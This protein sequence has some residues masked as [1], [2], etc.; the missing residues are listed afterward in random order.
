MPDFYLEDRV[1]ARADHP[2]IYVAGID[3]VGIGALAGPVVAA[4]VVLPQNHS[5][6]FSE[7]NDSKKLPP[8]TRERLYELIVS[9]AYAVGIGRA[10]NDKIDSDGIKRAHWGAL[11]DAFQEVDRT[12]NTPVAAVVD[13]NMLAL[14]MAHLGGP[15]SIFVDRADSLSCSV[16]AAS[17]VAKVTRDRFMTLQAR[18]HDVYG[19]EKNKGYGTQEHL[20]AL[21]QHGPCELHRQS[22]APVKK[23]TVH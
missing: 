18:T 2:L 3:E 12:L 8:R 10:D 5:D 21:E 6:W 17:I 20:K 11:I 7:L 14:L 22:F 23:F 19:F 15:A 13:G 1:R 16:A 9:S 4:A